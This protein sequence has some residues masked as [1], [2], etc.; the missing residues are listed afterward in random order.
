MPFSRLF[1]LPLSRLHQGADLF[2]LEDERSGAAGGPAEYDRMRRQ[3]D[4]FRATK[5]K[6]RHHELKDSRA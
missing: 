3:R 1:P 5:A 6:L 4:P 2:G